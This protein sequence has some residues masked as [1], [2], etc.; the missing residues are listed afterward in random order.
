MIGD[1]KN[2]FTVSQKEQFDAIYNKEME[3]VDV[4]FTFEN[5]EYAAGI[6]RGLDHRDYKIGTFYLSIA[7]YLDRL[8]IKRK[9]KRKMVDNKANE[10]NMVYSYSNL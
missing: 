1:W 10:N 2:W 9:D 7:F 4:K 6:M 8:K 5:W 3:N